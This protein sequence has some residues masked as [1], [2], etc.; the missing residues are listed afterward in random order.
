M[1]PTRPTHPA[2]FSTPPPPPSLITGMA[3]ESAGDIVA[4]LGLQSPPVGICADSRALVAGDA[5]AAFPGEVLDGRDFIPA[6]IRG[7]ASGVFWEPDNFEWRSEW[8]APNRPVANLRLRLGELADVVYDSPSA[9][10]TV[11]A[12]TGA[13][14]KTTICHFIAQLLSAVGIPAGLMGTV[15]VGFP[16]ALRPSAMTTPDAASVHATLRELA[17]D[18]AKAAAVE[19]SSHGLAQNRLGGARIR[20]GVFANIGRDHLDYH[21]DMQSYRA[22]KAKLFDAPGMRAAVVNADDEFGAV[23]IKKLQ[24]NI[25]VVS[26]GENNGDFRIAN[27]APDNDGVKFKIVGPAFNNAQ[28]ESSTV[29]LCAPGRHNALNFLA[30]ALAAREVVLESGN[31]WSWSEALKAAPGLTFPEGRM[32]RVNPGGRPVVFVDYAHAPEALAAALSAARESRPKMLRLVFGCGGNRDIGKRKLMGEVAARMAD[33]VVVTDDNPRDEDPESVAAPVLRVVGNKAE[34]IADRR[35]AI[36]RAIESA[37]DDDAIVVAGKGHESEQEFKNGER[38][39]FCD[40]QVATEA[41]AARGK[42]R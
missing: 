16:G 32:R 24:N 27:Y 4:G 36:F 3:G 22:A 10:M 33:A 5:F 34:R 7:G 39:P 14:G 20:A 35:A 42:L 8:Q 12:V 21:G 18:G 2:N 1:T 17:N 28:D 30:A 26:F 19:A 29:S 9:K 40:V 6:A 15:G 38:I 25:S 11:A 23:L 13:N 31:E 41:L 37:G